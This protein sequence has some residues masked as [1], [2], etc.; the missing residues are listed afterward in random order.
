MPFSL[1]LNTC[2][3]LRIHNGRLMGNLFFCVLSTLGTGQL[4]EDMHAS[5]DAMPFGLYLN[6]CQVP[7]YTMAGLGE[8]LFV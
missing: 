5:R 8:T 6:A 2:Q 7:G 1:S 3:G 4:F